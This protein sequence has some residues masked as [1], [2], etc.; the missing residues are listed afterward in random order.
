MGSNSK[1]KHSS[2]KKSGFNKKNFKQISNLRKENGIT[3]IAMK[4]IF[5]IKKLIFV[6]SVNSK[7][8]LLN[9]DPTG[10]KS[11]STRLLL[12]HA[13]LCTC[14]MRSILGFLMFNNKRNKNFIHLALLFL[15]LIFKPNAI[16]IYLRFMYKL[17][18][19]MLRLTW[20]VLGLYPGQA[21][22]NLFGLK[23]SA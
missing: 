7:S 11:S 13:I 18:I 1:N 12:L 14:R 20:A 5:I 4:L 15:D 22:S 16:Y 8:S 9:V 19:I 3:C 6:N 23:N 10:K 21:S 17:N 2:P